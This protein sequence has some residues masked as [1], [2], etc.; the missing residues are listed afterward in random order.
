[1]SF[2]LFGFFFEH[3]EGALTSSPLMAFGFTPHRDVSPGF[4]RINRCSTVPPV[5]REFYPFGFFDL[6]SVSPLQTRS[7][8]RKVGAD[9]VKP[10]L[11]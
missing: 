10:G 8:Y 2:V 6:P 9:K 11:S 3:L 1:L 7:D 5:S 4:Q